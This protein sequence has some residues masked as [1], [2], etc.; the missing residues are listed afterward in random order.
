MRACITREISFTLGN[1]IEG[2]TGTFGHIEIR[3]TKEEQDL[4]EEKLRHFLDE[5]EL[6]LGVTSADGDPHTP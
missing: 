4:V 5:A 2:M 3:G 6:I 1:Q